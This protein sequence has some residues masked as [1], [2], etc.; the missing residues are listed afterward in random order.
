MK[1]TTF[2]LAALLA[3]TPSMASRNPDDNCCTVW[4]GQNFISE[5]ETYCL[6]Q[7]ADQGRQMAQEIR[8]FRD[9]WADG[10][11]KCGKN[12]D[13][14]VCPNGFELGPI[15]G[16]RELGYKCDSGTIFVEHGT[17]VG[18]EQQ[19]GYLEVENRGSSIILSLHPWVAKGKQYLSLDREE[20]EQIL[21][22]KIIADRTTNPT[23]SHGF[24]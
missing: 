6:P 13:A 21:W 4:A 2:T 5:H 18:A 9:V 7:G 15:D 24:F 3:A 16:Q 11:I 22:N 17:E 10:S 14:L 23:I 8:I 12:V 19:L 1:Q 20:K